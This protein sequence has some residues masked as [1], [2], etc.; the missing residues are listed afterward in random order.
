[1]QRSIKAAQVLKDSGNLAI[2]SN[3]HPKPYTGFFDEVQEIYQ[4]VVPEWSNPSTEPSTQE[5]IQATTAYINSTGLFEPVL[6]RTYQWTQDYTAQEYQKLLDTYSDHRT[7]EESRRA[8]LC[9]KISSLIED[10]Y[11][12]N[13]TKLYLTVLYIAKKRV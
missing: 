5:T 1:M 3:E 6:V 2:F 13:I 4:Q 9:D 8:R 7:L 10:K 12:G 11:G